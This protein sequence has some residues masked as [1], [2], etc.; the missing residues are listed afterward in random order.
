[1]ITEGQNNVLSLEY[2]SNGCVRVIF[3]DYRVMTFE[4]ESRA[5]EFILGV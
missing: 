3:A 2:L 5:I 4:N 1:M